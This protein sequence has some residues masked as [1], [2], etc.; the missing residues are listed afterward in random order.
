M[1]TLCFH[2]PLINCR[3]TFSTSFQYTLCSVLAVLIQNTCNCGHWPRSLELLFTLVH[4]GKTIHYSIFIKCIDKY[5]LTAIYITWVL[6]IPHTQELWDHKQIQSIR[7]W[8][9][10]KHDTSV[11]KDTAKWKLCYTTRINNMHWSLNYILYIL[12]VCCAK[13]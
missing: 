7:V 11:S 1:H 13:I 3:P 10:T 5:A 9:S 4:V 12:D 8:Q 6:Y 2:L